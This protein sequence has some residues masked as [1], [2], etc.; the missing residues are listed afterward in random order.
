MFNRAKPSRSL[1]PA[2]G[3]KSGQPLLVGSLFGV[4]S[5]DAAEGESVELALE[6]VFDLD[7]DNSVIGA[8]GAVYWDVSAAKV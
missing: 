1:A 3:V 4:C 7:K 5:Y 2:G 6:G 8:G